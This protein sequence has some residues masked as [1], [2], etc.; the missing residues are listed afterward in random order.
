MTS[1]L[2]RPAELRADGPFELAASARFLEGFTPAARADAAREPGALRLA[3]PVEGSWQHA[4]VLIRQRAP[5]AVAISV[6]AGEDVAEQAV[7]QVRRILSL[8]LPGEGFAAVGQADPVVG[9]LQARYPGLR[10]VLFH[11]PYEAACWAVIAARLRMVQAASIKQR[12]AQRYGEPVEVA[13]QQ[14]A[15]FP[16]PQALLSIDE[17]LGLPE[18]K[19]ERLRSVAR[20]ASDGLLDAEELRALDPE[21]AL[22][23]LQRLPGIGPFSAELILIRGAGHPDLFPAN[24]TRL[25]EEM[26]E[27]YELPDAT[28]AELR[29]LAER[30]KPYRSWVALLL[31]THRED[32]LG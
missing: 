15:S 24:E 21:E 20:A 17:P 14:L 16:S 7:R 26:R 27:L 2:H 30:W 25:H 23:R 3:F 12:I 6:E 5:G 13:G 4:G 19:G 28:P 9:R 22:R 11:S 18:I 10:P 8:D 1:T 31:R 32:R 29:A